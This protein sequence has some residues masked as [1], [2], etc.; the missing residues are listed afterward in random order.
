MKVL[1]LGRVMN[2]IE[3]VVLLNTHQ[4]FQELD[5]NFLNTIMI[6]IVVQKRLQVNIICYTEKQVMKIGLGI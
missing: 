1:A 2:S 3:Q 6:L 4:V 5:M